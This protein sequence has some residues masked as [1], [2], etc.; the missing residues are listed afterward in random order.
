MKTKRR[1]RIQ[2]AGWSKSLGDRYAMIKCALGDRLTGGKQV[3]A[4]E[5]EIASYVGMKYALT[6]NSGSSANLLAVSTLCSPNMPGRVVPG[7]SEVIT[8]ALTFPTTVA[9]IVQNNLVPVFVDSFF[10]EINANV[11]EIKDSIT[12]NTRIVMLPHMLGNPLQISYLLQMLEKHKNIFFIE[13]CCDALGAEVNYPNGVHG[14]VGSFGDISTFSFYPA[15]HITTGEG[16]AIATNNKTIYTIAKSIRDWGRECTCKAGENG[17][18]SRFKYK[19]D[20]KEY[21]HRYMYI[22]IGYNLN[23]TEMQAALG[24]S[25]LKRVDKFIKKRVENYNLLWNELSGYGKGINPIPMGGYGRTPSPFSFPILV[26]GKAPFSRNDLVRYLENHNIETRLLF[27]GNILKQQAFKDI[28]HRVSK[29]LMN[30]NE[31][32]DDAFFIG[33]WP[34]M[35]GGD[36]K[37]I[38]SVFRKFFLKFFDPIDGKVIKRQ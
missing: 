10:G 28:K 8:P 37:Y 6:T 11:F 36:I 16:G 15:H 13:D 24:R 1:K 19:V 3:E 2:Y 21:D 4:F 38:G 17:C 22:N 18:A 35:N 23:M 7:K 25:Q 34:G 27:S 12:K 9:P 32:M 30:T 29:T 26:K 5:K 20:G 33:V 31:M 14:K